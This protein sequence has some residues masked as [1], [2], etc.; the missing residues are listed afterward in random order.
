MATIGS[1][2]IS[3]LHYA[4]VYIQLQKIILQFQ[5]VPGY[6]FEIN[7]GTWT[8]LYHYTDSVGHVKNSSLL[9]TYIS[10]TPY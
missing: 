7:T 4:Q 2:A 5:R 3:S 6:P 10:L 8:A 1:L 9:K